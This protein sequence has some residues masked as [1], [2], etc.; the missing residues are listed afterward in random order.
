MSDK[1]EKPTDHRLRELRKKGQVAKSQDFP[2]VVT[3]ITSIYTMFYIAPMIYKYISRYSIQM[4][5]IIP[6]LNIEVK[7]VSYIL[8]GVKIIFLVSLPV[9]IVTA[10]MGVIANYL[11]I[12]PLF[13]TKVFV[14]NLS[15]F[16]LFNNLKQKFSMRTLFDVTKNCIKLGVSAYIC[17]SVIKRSFGDIISSLGGSVANSLMLVSVLIKDVIIKVGLFFL[18]VGL[19]DYM[20]NK[21]KFM[22]DNMMS[23]H[24]V[25][26]EYKNMEG[27]P[28]LK[29]R[30]KEIAKE[31][32]YGGGAPQS[33]KG[34][35]AMVTNP[36]HIAIAIGYEDDYPAPFVMSKGTGL[37][38]QWLIDEAR[39]L[40]IPIVRN[41]PLAHQLFRE[42]PEFGYVPIDTYDVIAEIIKWA[43]SLGQKQ[44]EEKDLTWGSYE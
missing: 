17:Y 14:P 39:R 31:I 41:I 8:E 7:G 6:N 42:T 11:V 28:Q 5:K 29:G 13:S 34:A 21:Y 32:A 4:M 18:F 30:R 9:V 3:F 22:K 26:Q 15:K 19:F 23:K 10:F 33:P 40:D 20:Y 44:Q 2:A 27:D 35:K 37:D 25:K 12:G 16:N 24:E 38:A 36:T 1:T 43:I